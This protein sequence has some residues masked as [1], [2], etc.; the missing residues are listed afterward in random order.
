MSTGALL[1]Q[2]IIYIYNL[3]RTIHIC[4]GFLQNIAYF[5]CLYH[6]IKKHRSILKRQP[7]GNDPGRLLSARPHLC[8]GLLHDRRSASC[9]GT[10]VA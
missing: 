6:N 8:S 1:I 9:H 5:V 7:A 10:L 4:T 3:C 2:P